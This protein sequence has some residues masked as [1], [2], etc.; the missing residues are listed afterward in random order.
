MSWMALVILENA[1]KDG[2][3]QKATKNR[4][5][6]WMERTM[7]ASASATYRMEEAGIREYF[8]RM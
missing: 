5:P 6:L 7:S 4:T 1:F 3:L 8:S 2:P